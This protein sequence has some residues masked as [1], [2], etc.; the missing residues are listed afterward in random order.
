MKRSALLEDVMD[1]FE[2]EPTTTLYGLAMRLGVSPDTIT[3]ATRRAV[4][5]GDQQAIDLRRRLNIGDPAM[6][7]PRESHVSSE[8][9]ICP[10]HGETEF[11]I[12]K[13][14][15]QANGTQRYISRCPQCHTAEVV[16]YKKAAER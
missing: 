10:E 4:R 2:Q 7:R 13:K 14:G 15:F 9:K 16:R 5:R 1:L 12:H 8:T 11:R 6:G 3:L